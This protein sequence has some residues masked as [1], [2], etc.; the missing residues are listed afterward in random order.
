M[1]NIDTERKSMQSQNN[2]YMNHFMSI[3]LILCSSVCNNS[4]SLLAYPFLCKYYFN[5]FSIDNKNKC[6]K[7]ALL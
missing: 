5:A 6:D 7:L 3:K 2:L 1:K 4:K